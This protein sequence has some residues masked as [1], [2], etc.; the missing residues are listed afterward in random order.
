MADGV[1]VR[2][3]AA[4]REAAGVVEETYDGVAT[5]ADVLAAAVAA[6]PDDGRLSV[7]LRRCS[8][9]VDEAPVGTRPHDRVPVR[10]GS[11]VEVLPPFAGGAA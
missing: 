2:Y 8:Y 10:D 11:V 6:R 9:L 4:A 3:W 1:V 5:V 7:V